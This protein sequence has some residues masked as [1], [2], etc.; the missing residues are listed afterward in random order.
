MKISQL[1]KRAKEVVQSAV[2]SLGYRFQKIRSVEPQQDL[3]ALEL[4]MRDLRGRN[5][6]PFVLQIGAN[7]GAT[8]DPIHHQITKYGLP[9]VLVE[10]QPVAFAT[11]K[12]NY[13]SQPDVRFEQALIAEG[14]GERELYMVDPDGTEF[15][16]WCYQIASL[17]R[18]LVVSL[19]RGHRV[20]MGVPEDVE[21]FVKAVK[22]PA[23]TVSEVLDAHQV[24]TVDI[25]IVDTMG[26]DFEI[27]KLF[28][29][30]RTMPSIVSFEETML[31]YEDRLAAY[32]L[33]QGLGYG[34]C[35]VGVDTIGY[36]NFRQSRT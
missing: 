28:P 34:L 31:S 1:S 9:A 30:E 21:S 4:M 26:F 27:L 10:P 36:L 25:L 16:A 20:A 12:Q 23:K 14:G 11:L 35:K 22:I 3:D 15:G 5:P 13:A 8:A 6:R 2:G 29:F 33:L 7:D 32:A 17:D 18:S 24:S 19:L